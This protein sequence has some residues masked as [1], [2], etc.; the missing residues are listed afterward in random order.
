V[1]DIDA[2][3]RQVVEK[4]EG[5]LAC[6]VVDLGSGML[7]GMY[8]AAAGAT[9]LD[10]LVAAA[11][12]DLFRGSSVD[13]IERMV[14]QHRGLPERNGQRL[15][16]IHVTSIRNFHFAKAIAGGRAVIVLVTAKSTNIGMGWAQ[17]KAVIPEVEARVP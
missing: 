2:S 6:G 9:L 12:M 4:V 1:S 10:E 7:L 17:L 8:N 16:E 13:R 3:C 15:E 11:T 5:A 14:R